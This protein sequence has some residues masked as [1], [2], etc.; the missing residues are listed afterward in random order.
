MRLSILLLLLMTGLFACNKVDEDTE[1]MELEAGS[2]VTKFRDVKF[3]VNTD[4]V[5]KMSLSQGIT[6]TLHHDN[7]IYGFCSFGCVAKFRA[8]PEAYLK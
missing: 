6:D 8:N 2:N 1:Q 4:L 7:K 3:A 5:C